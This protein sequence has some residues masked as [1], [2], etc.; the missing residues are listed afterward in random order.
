[1]SDQDN[2]NNNILHDQDQDPVMS[3][4]FNREQVAFQ[5]PRMN[6][7]GPVASPA[8]QQQQQF[9]ATEKE[10]T[11][12][13]RIGL[14]QKP[15][16]WKLKNSK[17]FA[18]SATKAGD[19]VISGEIFPTLLNDQVGKYEQFIG[20]ADMLVPETILERPRRRLK[21]IETLRDQLLY[22]TEEV[23]TRVIKIYNLLND[24]IFNEHTDEGYLEIEID[25][26]EQCFNVEL[27][28]M[29]QMLEQEVERL[30][31]DYQ[32][33]KEESK[34]LIEQMENFLKQNHVI[35]QDFLKTT[36]R[37]I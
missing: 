31:Q 8:Y 22:E 15:N 35:V 26:Y 33:A 24:N 23:Q 21:G 29:Q 20:E 6:A 32:R 19:K 9:T 13:N 27:P 18:G 34:N 28:R 14:E 2:S 10:K 3:S 37:T 11:I 1:M 16:E 7:S 4:S 30:R 17:G 5:Q 36:Q 25:H 12:G